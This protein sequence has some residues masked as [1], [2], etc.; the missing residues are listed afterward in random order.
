MS[1]QGPGGDRN[2]VRNRHLSPPSFKLAPVSDVANDP[3]TPVGG[4]PKVPDPAASGPSG[5]PPARKPLGRREEAEG[6]LR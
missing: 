4:P 1:L 5:P 6:Q 3:G 2:I